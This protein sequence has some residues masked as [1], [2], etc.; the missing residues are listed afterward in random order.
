MY[1]LVAMNKHIVS[2][3][4]L[5]ALLSS[6]AYG[7]IT[8][9]VYAEKTS[10]TVEYMVEERVAEKDIKIALDDNFVSTFNM[11]A[12]DTFQKTMIT[13]LKYNI[14]DFE[15]KHTLFKPPISL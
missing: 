4:I 3:S 12:L 14:Y 8:S 5:L 6:L 11:I 2:L 7:H 13:S 9:I 15:L 1:K 10:T